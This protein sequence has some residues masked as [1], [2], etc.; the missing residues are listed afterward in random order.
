MLTL[1]E[2]H[3]E[4]LEGKSE[5]ELKIYSIELRLEMNRLKYEIEWHNGGNF[6]NPERSKLTKINK[7]RLYLRDTYKVIEKTGG[8][9]KP[10]KVDI[11]ASEFQQNIPYIKKINYSIGGY[12]GGFDIYEVTFENEEVQV[13]KENPDEILLHV[14]DYSI[15]EDYENNKSEKMGKNEFLKTIKRLRMGEWR[16]SYLSEDYGNMIIDGASWGVEVHY[17]NE[18]NNFESYGGN[19]YPYNFYE[20]NRLIEKAFE[21]HIIFNYDN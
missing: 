15:I 8:I 19:A 17:S 5:K 2:H 20:F 3:K 7:Y 9:I 18:K 1:R 16:S 12:F 13:K 6:R 10:P 4:V 14:Y 21:K 11:M